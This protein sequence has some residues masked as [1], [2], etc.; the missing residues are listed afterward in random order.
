LIPGTLFSLSNN[1]AVPLT[2]CEQL[3]SFLHVLDFARAI[4]TLLP[5]NLNS[6]AHVGNPNTVGLLE[7]IEIIGELTGKRDLLKVG[8]VPYRKDQVMLLKP[9]CKTLESLGWRPKVNLREG[10]AHMLE[11]IRIGAPSALSLNDDSRVLL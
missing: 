5:Y 7:V 1:K 11:T 2:N 9:A 6:I 10:I 4:N 3:W 8:S